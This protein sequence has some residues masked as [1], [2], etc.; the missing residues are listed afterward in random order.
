MLKQQ[1]QGLHI[2]MIS[3]NLDMADINLGTL[4]EHIPGNVDMSSFDGQ[5]HGIA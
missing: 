4:L 2:A 3:S 1:L 5:I